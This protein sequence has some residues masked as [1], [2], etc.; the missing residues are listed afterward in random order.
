MSL[1][2]TDPLAARDPALRAL[3]ERQAIVELGECYSRAVA[4]RDYALLESLYTAG[5]A[6]DASYAVLKSPIFARG[7]RR[8]RRGEN[9]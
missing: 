4:R 1:R 7:Q 2:D 6:D 5:G 9:A 8:P 3:L